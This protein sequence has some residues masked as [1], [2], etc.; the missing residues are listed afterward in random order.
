[1]FSI[2]RSAWKVR[3]PFMNHFVKNNYI[4]FDHVR[5]IDRFGNSLGDMPT[6]AAVQVAK[7]QGMD[8]LLIECESEPPLCQITK[9]SL[10]E[11]KK[12][13]PMRGGTE[14]YSFDPT[15]RPATVIFSSSIAV[16][17]MERKI[18]I[19]R[20]HL[21]EKKRCEI[22]I[23]SDINTVDAH[24]NINTLVHQ[25]LGEVKDIAKPAPNDT[26]HQNVSEFRI[27]LWP[28][29]EDQTAEF[30]YPQ[31]NDT[32]TRTGGSQKMRLKG[33]A[34]RF[35]QVRARIDP[36]ILDLEKHKTPFPPD[37]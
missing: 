36:K 9:E 30:Q 20:K 2:A 32:E 7:S 5:V 18:D 34:R 11:K 14:G 29:N 8:L 4:I 12:T 17:D 23:S 21:L 13:Q 27:K 19:L 25:I 28:C 37:E 35:R 22:I 33:H 3:G 1:M 6:P 26:M 16:E 10:L 31:I 24:E 15:L